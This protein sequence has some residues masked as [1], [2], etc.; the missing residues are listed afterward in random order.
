MAGR[1]L[2]IGAS[3]YG[4]GFTELPAAE[5]DVRLM[6]ETLEARGYAAEIVAPE[7]VENAGKLESAISDFCETVSAGI[8]IV[9]FSGHGLS[10]DDQ[11]WIIPAGVSRLVASRSATQRV[12][13]DLSPFVSDQGGLVIFLIDA[14]REDRDQST[15]KGSRAWTHGKL[16]FVDKKFIRIFGCA[17]KELCHVWR[18]GS[19]GNDV[20]VFTA[21]LVQALA[22]ESRNETLEELLTATGA[23]CRQIA[24]KANPQLPAQTPSIGNMGGD[25]NAAT[26]DQL[27][28]QPIFRQV[29][30]D[31][32]SSGNAVWE[33]FDPQ[34]LHCIVVESEHET[35]ALLSADPLRGKV[36]DMFLEAGDSIWARFR[37]IWLGRPLVDGT[38]RDVQ[39]DFD[40]G[41]VLIS[42]LRVG[43]A[44]KSRP[45]LESAIR[46][47]VQADLAFFD[48][49]RFEPGVMFLLGIRAATRRGVTL[50]SHGYGWRE[51]Q[52][53][54]E[55]PFNLSDLQVFSHTDIESNILSE[56][57]VVR[58]FIEATERG[59]EQL[60]L[61][62][63][64][65]DLPAYDSLRQLGS[66]IES[67]ATIPFEKLVLALCS[68]R[69]QHREAWRYVRRGLEKALQIRGVPKPR[70]RRLIDLGSSQLVS[71]A[72]YEHI[73]RVSGCV[74][75]W[76]LFSP[77]SF[78]E[79][80]V[81]LAV[82]PWGAV[83]II[84]ERYLPGRECAARVKG[85]DGQQGP[86]LQQVALMKAQ[87]EPRSYRIGGAGAF[88]DLAEALARRRPFDEK[89]PSYNWVHHAV[90]D[91][92]EPVSVAYPEVHNV[93]D[94]SAQSLSSS[95]KDRIE[96]AQTLFAASKHIKRDCERAALEQRIAAWLYLEYRMKPRGLSEDAKALYQ[97]LG[98]DTAAAL[99][100][101]DAPEDFELAEE[102]LKKL[103][104]RLT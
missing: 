10:I 40:A 23:E 61:Q 78:L 9:Y 42:I 8:G 66:E 37:R 47:V 93:L 22:P 82:S 101:S 12:S 89:E 27:I 84:E 100:D 20:S 30:I 65:L 62:P 79:L 50:C 54:G 33:M 4:A 86:E 95:E 67:W 43:D 77:S 63:G 15:G 51:G 91:A 73:R 99:Y 39:E 28:R 17:E 46:A 49:T 21:A 71:Q 94:R 92:I 87:L 60:L 48:L 90:R 83:Q 96:V 24:A 76:S 55:T 70:V 88:D 38:L 68:F 36:N 26:L 13:T 72:L 7:T 85:P 31:V 58:R 69:T 81:R 104:G 2:L 56:D 14:C 44:F 45:A 74:M 97:K 25:I 19:N 41:R 57:P 52:Q 18:H 80:G 75:D 1:A 6:K 5:N 35:L 29:S 53:G 59:F 103:D 11:E 98:Q 3:K 32:G 16:A 64:Y 34:R 102:I